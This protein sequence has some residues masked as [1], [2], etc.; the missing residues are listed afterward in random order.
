MRPNN[1]QL[2][3]RDRDSL[4]RI[5]V[6]RWRL[7]RARPPSALYYVVPGDLCDRSVSVC[8]WIP[9]SNNHSDPFLFSLVS[10]TTITTTTINTPRV[11]LSLCCSF[12][13]GRKTPRHR[14]LLDEG[15]SLPWRRR[16]SSYRGISCRWGTIIGGTT[17]QRQIEIN[18]TRITRQTAFCFDSPDFY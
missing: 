8:S 10:T 17:L 15:K 16:R 6:S 5:Y 1:S 14:R 18:F 7:V 13:R 3:G 9:A 11:F 2:V 12:A 4:S